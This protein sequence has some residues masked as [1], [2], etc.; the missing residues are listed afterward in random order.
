MQVS[1]TYQCNVLNNI[2]DDLTYNNAN[3]SLLTQVTII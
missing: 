3:N 1:V 2:D